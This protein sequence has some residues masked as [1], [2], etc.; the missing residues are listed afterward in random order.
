MDV[1][2]KQNKFEIVCMHSLLSVTVQLIVFQLLLVI[3]YTNYLRLDR[4]FMLLQ[5]RKAKAGDSAAMYGMIGKIPD[6]TLVDDFVR[7]Y[8]SKVYM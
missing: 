4:S 1:R 7:E 2:D 3:C 6:Q 5:G 8:F